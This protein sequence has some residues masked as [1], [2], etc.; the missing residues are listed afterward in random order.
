M[1]LEESSLPE[2][3]PPPMT[4]TLLPLLSMF[5]LSP[6][7]LLS[8]LALAL[9]A[10]LSSSFLCLVSYVSSA[11][12][13]ELASVAADPQLLV[14]LCSLAM[15]TLELPSSSF[16]PSSFRPS[17][18]QLSASSVSCSRLLALALL[19]SVLFLVVAV[20]HLVECFLPLLLEY[21]Q[22]PFPLQPWPFLGAPCGSDD[23]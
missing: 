1:V 7:D 11:S 15:E 8:S 19:G 3:L 21:L 13:L 4:L 20:N 10:M 17:R 16:P 18:F 6:V 2:F 23:G 22:L 9:A 12:A 14:S 5:P